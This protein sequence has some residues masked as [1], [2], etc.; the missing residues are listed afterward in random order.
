MYQQAGQ[1]EILNSIL[2]FNNESGAQIAG[3]VAPTVTYSDVQ[4]GFS[5]AGNISLNPVFDEQFAIV[6]PSPAIDAGNPDP[7]YNDVIPPGQGGLR[8]DMGYTGGPGG[9][10]FTGPTCGAPTGPYNLTLMDDTVLDTQSFNVCGTLTVGPDY[11][12]SGPS[13][14]LTLRAGIAVRLRDGFGVGVDGV[15]TVGV[16]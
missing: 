12:V 5:G 7:A 2:F 15:L 10:F 13:G 9:V 14:N 8:N 11:V 4:T 3:P 16:D 6:P 1:L